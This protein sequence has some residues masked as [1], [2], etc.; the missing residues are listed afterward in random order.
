[1]LIDRLPI[2]YKQRNGE[3]WLLLCLPCQLQHRVTACYST[4]LLT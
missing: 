1:M 4:V 2:Y 3:G